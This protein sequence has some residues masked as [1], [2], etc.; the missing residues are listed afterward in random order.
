[1]SNAVS[2]AIGVLFWAAV[3]LAFTFP[4]WG[5]IVAA[6]AGFAIGATL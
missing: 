4:A 2:D 6:A 5:P 3:F 1:M